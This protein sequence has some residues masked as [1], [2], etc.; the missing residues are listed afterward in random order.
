VAL[1]ARETFEILVRDNAD[2]VR[3]FLLALIKDKQLADEL[4]QET[5]VTAWKKIDTYDPES[6]FGVWVRRIAGTLALSRKRRAASGRMFYFDQETLAFLEFQFAKTSKTRGDKWDEKIHALKQCLDALPKPALDIISLHYHKN[7]NCRE[8]GN[9]LN[10]DVGQAK[11]RLQG[12][13][14]ILSDCVHSK[15]ARES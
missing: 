13:R 15:L 14:K 1:T 9:R 8:I 6:S 12:T 5:F 11:K 2:M 4:F 3:A 10:L 7:H